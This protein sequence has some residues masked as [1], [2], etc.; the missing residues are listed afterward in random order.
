[1]CNKTREEKFS[2]F[3]IEELRAGL[4]ELPHERRE[5]L[6]KEYNL[7]GDVLNMALDDAGFLNFIERAVS[8][9]YAWDQAH[10]KEE[11]RKLAINYISSDLQGLVKE[12]E[13]L[14]GELL[15]TPE[16]FAEL[17]KMAHNGEISS[18]AAKDVLRIMI[19]EGG[20]P[21]H[22]VDSRGLKQISDSGELEKIVKEII[23][24]NPEAVLD[25]KKGKENAAQFLVG[26][27][28]KQT[29]GSAN[30]KI[31][32]EILAKLIK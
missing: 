31:V 11:L 23:N 30:P 13:L 12:K 29:R 32:Y 5:R 27:V 20:D 14:W 4:P 6:K 16:N 2:V 7:S 19:E 9:L 8:E 18:R 25:I 17:M 21:S 26:Q 1:M 24:A 10:N 22:I 28:M 3:N 15:V